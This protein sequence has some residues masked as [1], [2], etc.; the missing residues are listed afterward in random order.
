MAFAAVLAGGVA[1]AS[2]D[3]ERERQESQAVR[4]LRGNL[5]LFGALGLG[6]ATVGLG[7]EREVSESDLATT[8]SRLVRHH[9]EASIFIAL[10]DEL[11]RTERL[12]DTLDVERLSIGDIVSFRIGPAVAPLRRVVEQLIRLIDVAAPMIGLGDLA[13]PQPAGGETR[14]QRR[15][16]AR[17][18]AQRSSGDEDGSAY[19]R[20]LRGL[21][22]ALNDDLDRSGM[23]DV[24]VKSDAS[25]R[26]LL[27]LDKRFVSD[28]SLE[29]LHTSRFTVVG[30][31]TEIWPTE[32]DFVMLFRRSVISLVPALGQT[33]TWGMFAILA[34]IARNL[35]PAAAERAAREAAGLQPEATGAADSSEQ[36]EPDHES[37]GAVETG[38]SD[39]EA[40]S[41]SQD[42]PDGD[43]SNGSGGSDEPGEE[44]LLGDVAVEALTAAV[45]GP[46]IQVLPLAVCA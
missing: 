45:S 39:P 11:R 42:N 28:Q 10:Y 25:P 36:A 31:V 43:G 35:D 2:E 38:V 27:T 1:L 9:T 33:F 3:V 16:Q 22:V 30:K 46:A 29:L 5:R 7:G 15:Q 24:V 20:S 6:G 37:D 21:L 4:N 8:E 34:A 13:E 19:L 32:S 17:S 14:Q 41:E 18:A 23:V 40:E 26:V 12:I 44:V